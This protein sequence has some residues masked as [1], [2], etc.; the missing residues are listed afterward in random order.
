MVY[1]EMLAQIAGGGYISPWKAIPL[2]LMTLLWARLLSWVDKD[3]PA[4]HLPRLP[5]NSGL[6]AG[7]IAA[8][9]AFFFLPTFIVAFIVF[10]VLLMIEIGVYL[11]IRH[12]KVGLK[13]LSQQFHE[14]I[15]GF[16][17]KEKA[18]AV[19]PDLMQI[20]GRDGNIMPA[21]PEE[22]PER[23][24]YD[25]VQLFIAGPLMKHAEQLDM[26]PSDNT[27]SIKYTI[28]GFLYAGGEIN[29][30]DATEAITFLKGVSGLDM[31]E[32]RKPQ[33]GL[34]KLIILGKRREVRIQTAGSATGE[35]MRLIVEPKQRHAIRLED[36]GLLDDQLETVRNSIAANS[37]IVLVAAIKGQGLT[38]MLYALLRSHDAFLQH[39]H[40][41]ERAPDQELEGITQN[42]LSSSATP[43][44][45]AKLTSWVVS[46]QPDVVMINRIDD[47]GT[48]RE[49]I[50]LAA[51]GKRVYVGFR[52]GSTFDALSMWRKLVGDDRL[53]MK[54]LEMVITGRVVR[55]LC[56]ACKVGYAPDPATLRKL[57]MEGRADTLY[58]ARAE[59]LRDAKGNVVPCEFCND[60]RFT[61]RVGVFEIFLI[62]DDVRQVVQQ[63]ASA[64]QLKALF[65][66][67]RS[68]FMQESALVRVERGETSIQEVLRILKLAD[69][70]SGGSRSVEG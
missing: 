56:N 69:S 38:S 11:G 9:F 62:D 32:K 30:S 10:L 58:Q 17:R 26:V 20:V 29:R 14:W 18:V 67:Q 64:N 25:A 15:S 68:R 70:G 19:T 6:M 53:A 57:N 65:R 60:L 44:E 16:G 50:K 41:I 7:F 37:G 27:V 31:N 54:H 8:L 40:S 24:A 63:G 22:S 1:G 33:T 48:A 52:A 3:A 21:P 61:G 13:D 34:M 28:D 23:H 4:A 36:L 66:K 35:Y 45:E 42:R 59:P 39:V 46:Q 2:L 51:E 55:K 43:Q 5:I 12:Q 49:L 47:P